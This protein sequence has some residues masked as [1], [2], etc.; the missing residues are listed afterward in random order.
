MNSPPEQKEYDNNKQNEKI[1][2]STLCQ[3]S[4]EPNANPKENT[5]TTPQFHDSSYSE[6]FTE[7]A[8]NSS[9]EKQLELS[10]V[11]SKEQTQA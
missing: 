5:Q 4:M 10:E 2:E 8:Q 3:A 1:T 6:I 11:F 7:Q 9:L